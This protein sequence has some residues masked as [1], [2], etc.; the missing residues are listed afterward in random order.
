MLR[1]TGAWFVHRLQWF[2][3]VAAFLG[4][5]IWVQIQNGS[6]DSKQRDVQEQTCGQRAAARGAVRSLIVR[7]VEGY[8]PADKAAILADMNRGLPPLHCP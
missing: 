5:I 8:P 1:H 6:Q 2:I 3:V 7:I 4:V